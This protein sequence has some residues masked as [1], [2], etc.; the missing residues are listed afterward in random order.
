MWSCLQAAWTSAEMFLLS[1]VVMFLCPEAR[2][3]SGLLIDWNT[4]LEVYD[5]AEYREKQLTHQRSPRRVRDS[6]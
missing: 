3:I 5:F 2:L 4:S 6:N 1:C